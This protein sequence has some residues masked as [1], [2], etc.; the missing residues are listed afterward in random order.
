MLKTSKLSFLGIHP[1]LEFPI[2]AFYD[3]KKHQREEIFESQCKEILLKEKALLKTPSDFLRDNSKLLKTLSKNS[4]ETFTIRAKRQTNKASTQNL[5]ENPY[6]NFANT[7]KDSSTLVSQHYY[8]DSFSSPQKPIRVSEKKSTLSLR[9]SKIR[10]SSHSSRKLLDNYSRDRS[11]ET[12]LKQPERDSDVSFKA[13]TNLQKQSQPISKDRQLALNFDVREIIRSKIDKQKQTVIESPEKQ[14]T[15]L[16]KPQASKKKTIRVKA[17]NN[18]PKSSL[19]ESE[20]LLERCQILDKMERPKPPNSDDIDNFKFTLSWN[21]E[22]IRSRELLKAKHFKFGVKERL[23]YITHESDPIQN[24][25]EKVRERHMRDQEYTALMLEESSIV[26]NSREN[27]LHKK[28]LDSSTPN[29]RNNRLIDRETEASNATNR[30]NNYGI[31]PLFDFTPRGD[32]LEEG[33]TQ[34]LTSRSQELELPTQ[35]TQKSDKVRHNTTIGKLGSRVL[36][37]SYSGSLPEISLVGSDRWSS[38]LKQKSIQHKKL[39]QKRNKEKIH[40]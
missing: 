29:R 20:D 7:E 12:I 13:T 19:R 2:R 26:R 28:A 39:F 1:D 16:Q 40:V 15:P 33:T 14:A 18:K 25:R 38:I 32:G 17:S 37:L 21:E 24:I 36:T 34:I 5:L 6:G 9:E 8:R 4:I 10:A 27:S 23:N 22:E 11:E 31:Q 30:L 3:L 35:R